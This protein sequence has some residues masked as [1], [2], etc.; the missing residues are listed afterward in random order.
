M[1]TSSSKPIDKQVD[2]ILRAVESWKMQV[3]VQRVH[4]ESAELDQSPVEQHGQVFTGVNTSRT[5][6]TR[7][8]QY[9]T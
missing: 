8:S 2:Q 5:M 1:T 7:Q 3:R 4:A 9:R 6:R